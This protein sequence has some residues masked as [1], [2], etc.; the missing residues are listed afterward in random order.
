[1]DA[2]ERIQ[3]EFIGRKATVSPRPYKFSQQ[4]NEP[5]TSLL[6]Y[7]CRVGDPISSF[8]R[9]ARRP[10]Q[11]QFQ[12]LTSELALFP[13]PERAILVRMYRTQD[14]HVKEI[15]RLLTPRE[16]KA[17]SPASEAVKRHR[18]A[19]R[20]RVVRICGRKTR[21]CSSSSA[22]GSIHDEKSALDYA[23][24]LKCAARAIRRP[25]EIV[26]RVYFEKPRHDH[27]AGRI[28]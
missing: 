19:Q 25:L 2:R 26:M 15:V 13:E 21:A 5:I 11:I 3:A 17:Q 23:A 28:D 10:S 1:M 6:R 16:L 9:P 27:P 14:L 12:K 4:K 18:R 20:E 7:N 8:G 24:R 22:P